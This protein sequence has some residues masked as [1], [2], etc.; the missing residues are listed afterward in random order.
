MRFSGPELGNDKLT[1][2]TL[3]IAGGESWPGAEAHGRGRPHSSQEGGPAA[4]SGCHSALSAAAEKGSGTGSP[5]FFAHVRKSICGG[6]GFAGH[7]W[8]KQQL[9]SS[10]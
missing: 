2:P 3:W 6:Q 9:N 4:G 5:D 8:A 10:V 1:V 7:S